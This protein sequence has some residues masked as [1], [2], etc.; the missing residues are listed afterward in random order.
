M[1]SGCILTVET[2]GPAGWMWKVKRRAENVFKTLT[3]AIGRM[4]LPSSE[5][6]KTVDGADLEV[7]IWYSYLKIL[8]LDV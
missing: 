3:G 8:G 1:D 6:R 7:K 4:A 2:S 5:M